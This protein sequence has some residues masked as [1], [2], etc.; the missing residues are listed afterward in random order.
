MLTEETVGG[1]HGW[2]IVILIVISHVND[3]NVTQTNTRL[4]LNT[5]YTVSKK[6]PPLNILYLCQILTD[7]QNFYTAVKRK[8]FATNLYDITHLTLDM[9]L[10]YLGK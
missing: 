9:L 10:H 4:V 1:V 2:I 6:F 7:F 5:N 8:K 3:I